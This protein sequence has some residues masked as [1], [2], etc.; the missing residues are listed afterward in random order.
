MLAA[1]P[2]AVGLLYGP[3]YHEAGWILQFLAVGAWFQMLEGTAGASLLALG[4]ARSLLLTNGARLLGF[5]IFVPL[6]CWVGKLLGPGPALPALAASTVGLLG[7]PLGA[8]PLLAAALPPERP[9]PTCWEGTFLGLLGGFIAA[10]A[11]RYLVTLWL[12][13]REG[14]SAWRYDLG[15]S[16]LIVGFSLASYALGHQLALW[17][18]GFEGQT[19][20]HAFADFVCVGTTAVVVWGATVGC[21]RCRGRFRL[22]VVPQGGP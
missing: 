5:L 8:G 6:G 10:D 1:G 20:W 9:A 14:M 21:V 11:V 15:L 22:R 7:S 2:A 13:R 3:A 19:R 18:L 12:S 16:A 4:Q 17:L